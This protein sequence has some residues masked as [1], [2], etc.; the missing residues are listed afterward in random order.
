MNAPLQPGKE[1]LLNL[2]A[3]VSHAENLTRI[4][5]E[6][7]M[8]ELLA[9]KASDD[10]IVAFLTGLRD[11][12]ET[13]DELV[14][15]AKSMRRHAEPV[16]D[17]EWPADE[18]L[19][20]TCGTGG[21]ARGTFNISTAT[22][23]VVA[24]AGVKVAKHGNRA[25]SSRCG[26]ADVLEA[27]GIPM[28]L[29]PK[30]MG[31]AVRRIGVGFFFAPTVHSAMRHVAAARKQIKSRTVFNLLGPLTNPAGAG[32]QVIGVFDAAYVEPVAR[33]L[34]ELGARRA[35]VVHGADGLDEISISGETAV[36]ELRDGQVYTYTISPEDF[37]LR[38][39][40]I[41]ALAG[42]DPSDNTKIIHKLF[43][44]SL[45]FREHGPRRDI[46]VANASAALVAAGRAKNFTEGVAL[47]A[48]SLDTG[49]AREKLDALVSFTSSA[50]Q[51]P[52][53]P[54]S[55]PQ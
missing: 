36:A 18:M 44:R 48:Q 20:D 46:L 19:V 34:G 25:F 43:G 23:F 49:A 24:G 35:F 15:F 4:E 45:L 53:P 37:G 10:Q 12:G 47:A 32:A 54:L 16:F 7:L 28:D 29:P 17:A 6:I 27:F 11:K 14:G 31:Q 39:A 52:P 3:K 21:D 51:F 30:I 42:G 26:S 1:S 22:A 8:N 40:P 55:N 2:L 33:A 41:E 38:R 9:G 5:A 50:K 13:V